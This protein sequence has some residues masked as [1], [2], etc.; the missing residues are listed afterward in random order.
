MI[1]FKHEADDF[2]EAVGIDQGDLT[3]LRVTIAMGIKNEKTLSKVVE[4]LETA[5]ED[6]EEIRRTVFSL[7]VLSVAEEVKELV[8]KLGPFGPLSLN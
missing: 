3:A 6:D 7:A 4:K 8:S 5:A 1:P 2:R